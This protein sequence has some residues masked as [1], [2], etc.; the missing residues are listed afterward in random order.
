MMSLKKGGVMKEALLET[1]MMLLMVR[2]FQIVAL[3]LRLF[4]F[5]GFTAD[6][7]IGPWIMLNTGLLLVS[8]FES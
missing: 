3:L 1:G 2:T 6:S 5:E 4:Y 7:C 8:Y